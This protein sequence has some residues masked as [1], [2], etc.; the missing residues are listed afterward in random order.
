MARIILVG[1]FAFLISLMTVAED[2][3]PPEKPINLLVFSKTTGYRHESISS[4]LKMLYDLSS[5][6]NWIITATE[7]GSLFNDDIL[8]K[9]DVIIFL[10]PTGD[11]LKD[12]EQKAFEKFAG[13]SKGVVGIH[14]AADFE[15]EWPYYGEVIG[16]YFRTHPPA[17]TGTVIFEDTQHPAMIPFK[18]MKVYTT[19]DEWYSFK[20]NPGARVNVLAKLDESSIKKANNDSWKMNDHPVIWW[21]EVKGTRSFYTVFGH[22]HEAFQDKL[23]IE[24]IQN[25]IN[26]AAR[27]ID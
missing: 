8:S 27:R 15:Y 17:Q 23:I 18:G 2:K 22:T 4:G 3:N 13:S 7:D 25:A 20:E 26:W 24:H 12:N 5:K 16:A 11:V 10:N 9:I 6:Q 21:Q 14:A 19:F 1:I